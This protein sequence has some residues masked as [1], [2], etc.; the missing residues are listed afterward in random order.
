MPGPPAGPPR[1][2]AGTATRGGGRRSGAGRDGA[3]SGKEEVE[4]GELQGLRRPEPALER[5]SPRSLAL[6]SRLSPV[7]AAR[8]IPETGQGKLEASTTHPNLQVGRSERGVWS[9]GWSGVCVPECYTWE[10]SDDSWRCCPPSWE[11]PSPGS[12]TRLNLG[13]PTRFS[14]PSRLQFAAL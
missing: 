13:L 12:S 8:T 2:R 3:R 1:R 14:G 7:S 9:W 5:S 10:G 4:P 6:R 11:S